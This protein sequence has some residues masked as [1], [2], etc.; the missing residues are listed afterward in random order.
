MKDKNLIEK[1]QQG[2]GECR[3]GMLTSLMKLAVY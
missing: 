1:A 2:D 3:V